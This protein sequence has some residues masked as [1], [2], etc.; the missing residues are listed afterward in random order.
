MRAGD[1]GAEVRLSG[2]IHRVRDHGGGLFI[3]LRAHYARERAA[4][5]RRAIIAVAVA[6]T[7]VAIALASY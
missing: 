5:A 1:V 7:V 2:W 6:L 3:D 4:A